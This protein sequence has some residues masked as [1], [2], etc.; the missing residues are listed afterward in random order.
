[1]RFHI[2]QDADKQIYNREWPQIGES[3]GS[4]EQKLR[5]EKWIRDNITEDRHDKLKERGVT[6]SSLHESMQ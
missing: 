6:V 2:M 3:K 4:S 5:K 1:M